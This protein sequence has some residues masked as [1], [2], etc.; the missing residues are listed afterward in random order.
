MPVPANRIVELNNGRVY[1]S[2]TDELGNF[3]VGDQFSVNGTT[4]EVT[5]NTNQFNLSG[6]NA[7]GPFSRNGGFS[8]VGVQLKEISNNTSLI[9]STGAADGN[10]V[11]TQFAVKTYLEDN[12]SKSFDFGRPTPATTWTINHNLGFYPSVELFSIGR[13]EID[14]DIVHTSENQVVVNFTVPTSG[15]AR[16]N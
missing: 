4:G 10:T 6:L 9:A 14:G 11:P 16:L 12:Y 13:Q 8:T 3:A 7:I 1:T 2:N 15:F 5:I